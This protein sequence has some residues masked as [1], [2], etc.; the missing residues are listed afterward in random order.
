[1]PLFKRTAAHFVLLIVK[2]LSNLCN[3]AGANGTTTLTDSETQTNVQSNS[4]DKL[5]CNLYVVARH[6]HL[7]ALGQRN[8]TGA[9]HCTEI[10]LGTILVSE[11]SVASTLFFLQYIDRSLELLVRFDLTGLAEYHTTLDFLL[12][13]TTEKQTYIVA[14]LTLVKNLTE[15]LNA[16]NN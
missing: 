15:H 14:S 16:C 12:V 13:D 5:Y 10:E 1:M 4:I 7:N 11:R 2:L 9:V 8:F 3:N 6:N